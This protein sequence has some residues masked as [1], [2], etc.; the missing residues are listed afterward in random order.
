MNSLIVSLKVS[1]KWKSSC[2]SKIDQQRYPN[3]SESNPTV[4][5]SL[6][7]NPIN[8]SEIIF[9]SISLNSWICFASRFT[10]L[11]LSPQLKSSIL[12]LSLLTHVIHQFLQQLFNPSIH[13]YTLSVDRR[14]HYTSTS[15]IPVVLQSCPQTRLSGFFF[16]LPFSLTLSSSSFP[17]YL[18]TPA[19]STQWH[20]LSIWPLWGSRIKYWWPDSPS[21]WFWYSSSPLQT[22]PQPLTLYACFSIFKS[23]QLRSLS[24]EL[25]SDLWL[26]YLKSSFNHTISHTQL[27]I[28]LSHHLIQSL[29]QQQTLHLSSI[30]SGCSGRG[31]LGY[32]HSC[33]YHYRFF[34]LKKKIQIDWLIGF[35]LFLD[36]FVQKTHATL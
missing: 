8:N 18:S 6:S 24:L 23:H 12:K 17:L 19:T 13:P 16:N 14:T 4:S 9:N 20:P 11:I 3:K 30:R 2:T 7:V 34:F 29:I 31:E 36:C 26:P 25:V 27:S 22:H 5:L 28:P 33:R 35:E 21:S 10:H 15:Y 1:L 32:L